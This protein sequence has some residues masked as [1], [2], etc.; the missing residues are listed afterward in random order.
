MTTKQ[1]T[2]QPLTIPSPY[3]VDQRKI[4]SRLKLADMLTAQS[5]A[6]FDHPVSWA[7]PLAQWGQ[8][9]AGA[10]TRRSAEKKQTRLDETIASDFANKRSELYADAKVMKPADLVAKWGM[11]PLVAEELKPYRDALTSALTQR[12]KT[13]VVGGQLV[14]EGDVGPSGILPND[15]N[16]PVIRDAQG[17]WV[18]NPI[19]ATAAQSAQGLQIQN[20]TNTMQ[21]PRGQIPPGGQPAPPIPAPPAGQVAPQGMLNGQP[22][23]NI[24][25][26]W[27]DNPEGN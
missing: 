24:N 25:G 3:A 26:Q 23:W 10:L 7:Q 20:P 12:E 22:V 15:P 8:A 11:D 14:R 27:Y 9:L 17:N 5:M 18:V 13:H 2:L 4:E 16:S 19:R 1:G 6:G 21:D